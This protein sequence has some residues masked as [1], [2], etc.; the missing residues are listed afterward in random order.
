MARKAKR[1]TF[2]NFITQSDKVIELLK[3]LSEIAPLP[4]NVLI[5][6]E[7]GTGKDLLAREIH[8][9]SLRKNYPFMSVN[10]STLPENLVE[11]ELFGYK[12]GA[13][14]DAKEDRTGIVEAAHRGTLF[15]DEIAEINLNIQAKL[16]NLIENKE[17]RVLG[18]PTPKHVDV[19]I[20]SATN[21]D[22]KKA[23]AENKFRSDLYYRMAEF[24]VNLLPL[25]ERKEDI[26]L[27]VSHFVKEFNS[28]FKKDI[29]GVSDAAMTVLCSCDFYGNVRE[30][31]NLLKQAIVSTKRNILWVEDFPLEESKSA[32]EP[33]KLIP[34]LE[35]SSVQ[36]SHFNE[37]TLAAKMQTSQT[38]KTIKDMEK[39]YI[40]HVLKVTEWNKTKAASLLGITRAT[41]YEKIKEYKIVT[42]GNDANY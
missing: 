22:L 15:L 33:E 34:A 16:L 20:I 37:E 32:K 29:K 5:T 6:G 11:S 10:C 19:R 4:I 31:K 13:F 9:T 17:L 3:K 28:G 30:L 36:E 42:R 1:K 7:T 35:K 27:L 40:E 8:K 21:K 2:T 14:T 41:L 12:K 26:P 18:N 24:T 23:I 39:E 38:F 25:R